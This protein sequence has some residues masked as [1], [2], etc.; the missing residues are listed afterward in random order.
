MHSICGNK[1]TK[2]LCNIQKHVSRK[3]HL[4]V[5]ELW[6]KVNIFPM[7]HNFEFKKWLQRNCGYSNLANWQRFSR[8]QT[9]WAWHFVENIWHIVAND[10]TE[11]FKWKLGLLQNLY[12]CEID[13]VPIIKNISNEIDGDINKCDF[14]FYIVW[15]NVNI[16]KTCLTQWTSIFKMSCKISKNHAK[17]KDPFKV[18]AQK[19]ILVDM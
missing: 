11:T 7:E 17:V 19:M 8:K 15:W 2:H 10:K 4:C 9:K 3:K 14:F 12:H 16:W 18:Y 5:F 13:S 1:C 6:A